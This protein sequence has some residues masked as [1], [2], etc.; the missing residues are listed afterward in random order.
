MGNKYKKLCCL[1]IKDETYLTSKQTVMYEIIE[2]TEQVSLYYNGSLQ[3]SRFL[4]TI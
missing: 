1:I 2:Y 4:A 3:Y